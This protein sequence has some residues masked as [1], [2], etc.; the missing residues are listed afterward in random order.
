[1]PTEPKIKRTFAFFDGQNVFN[2]AKEA[3]DYDW[4]SFDPM[5]LA[6]AVCRTQ[7]WELA[8]VHFYTGLPESTDKRRS[9][10][11]KK[12]QVMGTRGVVTFTRPLRYREKTLVLKDGSSTVERIGTEKGIDV[13]LALDVI[14]FALDG[15]YDVALIFSQDQD[16]SEAVDELKRIS[17]QI[18]RWIMA[19]S[20][21]PVSPTTTNKRGIRGSKHIQINKSLYD[22]CLDPNDYR[23]PLA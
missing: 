16:L 9:F 21:F 10:W 13:R 3:F 18:G 22:S 12:L 8:R 2:A 20:A 5:K 7:G 19:A 14:R 4:P 1:L 6:A 15:S 17:Q 23:G 11:N